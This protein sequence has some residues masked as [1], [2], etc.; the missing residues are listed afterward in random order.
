[1]TAQ[2]PVSPA[3]GAPP[4]PA[5]RFAVVGSAVVQWRMVPGRRST[6]ATT[7]WTTAH[8]ARSRGAAVAAAAGPAAG[9]GRFR[10]RVDGVVSTHQGGGVIVHGRAASRHAARSPYAMCEPQQERPVVVG[11]IDPSMVTSPARATGT[12]PP[13]VRPWR[14]GLRRGGGPSRTPPR[15]RP[16][17]RAGRGSRRDDPTGRRPARC[18]AAAA[19]APPRSRRS[20]MMTSRGDQRSRRRA[21]PPC[22]A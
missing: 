12:R 11:A 14:A 1:M 13:A 10:R 16:P 3:Y 5:N 22:A 7:H 21:P 15:R 8:G 4:P 6:G 18:T 20:R 2:T 9:A 19:A 17:G